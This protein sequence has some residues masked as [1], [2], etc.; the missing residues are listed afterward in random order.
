MNFSS[1]TSFEIYTRWEKAVSLLSSEGPDEDS[2]ALRTLNF[3][4]VTSNPP[5]PCLSVPWLRSQSLFVPLA[6]SLD[7]S[8]VIDDMPLIFCRTRSYVSLCT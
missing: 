6:G 1:V 8:V 5:V 7:F 3:E 2:T 4:C